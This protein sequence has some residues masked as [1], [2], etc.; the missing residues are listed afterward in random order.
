MERL[1]GLSSIQLKL[2]T[3]FIAVALFAI[4]GFIYT[5]KAEGHGYVQQPASRAVL[6]AKNNAGNVQYEP[7]SLEAPKGFPAAGPADGKIASA[8]G[9]FGGIL[10]EQTSTRWIKNDMKGGLTEFTWHLS[11]QHRTAKWHYYITK[12]GWD[13]NA[14]LKSSDFELIGSFDD[15]GAIPERDFTHKV[16]VPT[17]R[18]GYYVILAVWD[19]ADTG[20]AFYQVI[21]V[22]LTNEATDP[23]V[24]SNPEQEPEQNPEQPAAV[25]D[26]NE[27][28]VVTPAEPVQSD[29][30][31]WNASGFYTAGTKVQYKGKIYEALITYTAYGDQEWNPEAATTL[32]RLV[33]S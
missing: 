25:V 30:P 10:D 27:I 20:N 1:R 26:S 31:E 13:A 33:V 2:T 29:L 19:V 28:T 16:Q 6:G 32:W 9:K 5:D 4:S 8:G 21:D 18:T 23:V 11:A 24:P 14:P 15:Y 3:F 7:Q 17:D 22:N 12:K